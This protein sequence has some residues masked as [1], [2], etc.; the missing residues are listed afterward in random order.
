[1]NDRMQAGMAEATRL[2]RAARLAEATALILRTL[3]NA[4]ISDPSE[5]GPESATTTVEAEYH[6]INDSIPSSET[7]AGDMSLGR[8]I[9]T[10]I[11]SATS[12]P[13]AGLGVLSPDALRLP[14]RMRSVIVRVSPLT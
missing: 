12:R 10:P 4:H 1:M 3:G 11:E 9:G 13:A 7:S 8:K 5:E 6:T 2:T 14:G